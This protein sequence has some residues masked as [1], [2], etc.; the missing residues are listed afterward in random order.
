MGLEGISKA[1]FPLLKAGELLLIL[2]S[3]ED[4]LVAEL[5]RQV[6]LRQGDSPS[7]PCLY[8]ASDFL[9]RNKVNNM[10][11]VTLATSVILE[12]VVCHAVSME[13]RTDVFIVGPRD[14]N[15][16]PK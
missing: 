4:K 2:N 13:Y 7:C 1:L 12:P 11:H 9:I 10:I 6:L 14:F 3:L 16:T 15:H 5:L 8:S